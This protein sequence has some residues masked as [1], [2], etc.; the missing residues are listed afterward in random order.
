[1]RMNHKFNLRFA[2]LALIAVGVACL[3]LM[4]IG[5]QT[6]DS[7]YTNLSWASQFT[8]ELF[9][10]QWYPR[11]LSGLNAGA[12]SPV[13]FFYAP[14]PFYVSAAAALACQQCSEVIRLGLTEALIVLASAAAFLVFA[15]RVAGG[16]AAAVAS[17]VYALAPYHFA[18]DV[19]RRQAIGEAAAYIGMPLALYFCDRLVRGDGSR[20]RMTLGLAVSYTLLMLSHLPATLLFS[21]FLL[22]W[23]LFAA[24]R[25]QRAAAVVH[26]GLA[27]TLGAALA[28]GYLLPALFEQGSITMSALYSAYYEYHR[29][30]FFDGQDSPNEPLSRTLLL[31][32]GCP[33]LALLGVWM[34]V[35]GRIDGGERRALR[36]SLFFLA[37]AWWLMTPLSQPVWLLL[38]LLQKVQF[39]WRAGIVIDMA[40]AIGV[41]V[42]FEHLLRM[43]G[44]QRMLGLTAVIAPVALSLAMSAWYFAGALRLKS[45]PAHQTMIRQWIATGEDTDEYIPSGIDRKRPELTAAIARRPA[46]QW[47]SGNGSVIASA[48]Q[49][50]RVLLD[51]QL[52]QPAEVTVRQ[53]Q[54]SGWRARVVG[55]GAELPVGRDHDGLIVLQVPAG[56]NAVELTLPLLPSERFGWATSLC[57]LLVCLMLWLRGRRQRIGRTRSA[58]VRDMADTATTTTAPQ[59]LPPG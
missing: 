23:G 57:A 18:M 44:P 48:W 20:S 14:L 7:L 4:L 43:R 21:P 19:L 55:S 47:N 36:A 59:G 3:P 39:P 15:R 17:V 6:G 51:T 13:F 46:L 1:M 38:P 40:A 37:G 22:G 31:V 56:L 24:R 9:G 52:D 8:E 16:R 33:T 32:F 50:R 54:F 27:V 34:L 58:A 28:A 53:F 2:L 49:G 25:Q 35:R 26:V 10:G 29:W 42:A 5:P 11:W 41:A 45:D 30:F 12:G